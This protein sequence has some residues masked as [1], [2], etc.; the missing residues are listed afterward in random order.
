MKQ[1]T[2]FFWNIL[3]AFMWAAWNI[4]IGYFS[5]NLI[6]GIIRNWSS[7]LGASL[8]ILTALALIYWVYKKHGESSWE[9]FQHVSFVFTE[10]L[11]TKPGFRDLKR[12]YPALAEI[13]SVKKSQE[14]IFAGFLGLMGLIAFYVLALLLDLF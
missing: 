11:K 14:K 6:A 10:K 3:S 7:Q 13:L 2:F 8:S 1:R 5:G 12:R 9:Y 4:A